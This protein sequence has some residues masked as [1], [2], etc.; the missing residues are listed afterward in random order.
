MKNEIVLITTIKNRRDHFIQSFPFMVSQ[1]GIGYKL[2]IVDFCSDDGFETELRRQVQLREPSFSPFLQEIELVTVL[3]DLSFN[4]KKARNLAAAPYKRTN[5]VL[6][7]TDIDVFLGMD[8]LKKWSVHVSPR[9]TFVATRVGD[10]QANR[11]SRLAPDINPGNFFV[12]SSDYHAVGGM[13]ELMSAYG[14]GDCDLYHRLKL[15]G[16][17]EINPYNADDASQYSIVHGDDLRLDHLEDPRRVDKDTA[18]AKIYGNT[19]AININ[20]SFLAGY[21]GAKSE[22]LFL[23]GP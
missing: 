18:F 6:A 19:D 2:R 10:S 22:V 3:G 13:D 21:N 17:R 4:G 20:S 1:Y 9:E 5:Q 15:N 23:R 12:H 16:L 7:F 8:Y 11:M 14:G